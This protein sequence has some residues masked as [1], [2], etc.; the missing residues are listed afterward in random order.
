MTAPSIH[1]SQQSSIL[2]RIQLLI[3]DPILFTFSLEFVPSADQRL[4]PDIN[5]RIIDDTDVGIGINNGVRRIDGW[6]DAQEA[7]VMSRKAVD[8]TRVACLAASSPPSSDILDQ[9]AEPLRPA[10]RTPLLVRFG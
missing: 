8:T 9:I 1:I 2:L 7:A 3:T 5:D 10:Y 4:V 6:G